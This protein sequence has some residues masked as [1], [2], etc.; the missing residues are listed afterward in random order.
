MFKKFFSLKHE[1]GFTLIEL[2]V[3]IAIIGILAS[4][5]VVGLNV[6]TQNARDSRR[7]ADLATIQ[8]ALGQ[9]WADNQDYPASAES[10]QTSWNSLSSALSSYLKTLPKDPVNSDKNHYIYTKIDAN[11]YTLQATLEG[12]CKN[13]PQCDSANKHLW[14]VKP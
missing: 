4:I 2:L 11:N 3:V 8:S 14:I 6:A 10:N 9:Y 12:T 7:K 13:E 5:T 1:G